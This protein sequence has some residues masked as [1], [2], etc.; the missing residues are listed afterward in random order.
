MVDLMRCLTNL[1]L[2]DIPLLYCYTNL[3]SSIICCIS[4][5]D[6]YLFFVLLFHY[7]HHHFA[8]TLEI[9][10]MH[11]LF[12]L[13][14]CYQLNHQLL[15]LFFELLFFEAVFIASVVD[16]QSYQEVLN[17]IYCLHF[18]PC[19]LQKTEIHIFLHIFSLGSI[20]YLILQDGIAFSGCFI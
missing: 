13:Q 6:M 5:G 2:F 12:Y 3:N 18:Y 15:L 14:F 10:L 1:L 20:E 7:Q 4:C 8:S 11:L 9:F 17:H 16:F 19:F